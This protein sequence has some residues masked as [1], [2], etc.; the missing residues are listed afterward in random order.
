MPV[1]LN[2]VLYE[3]VKEYADSVYT[4]PSAYK[5]GFIVKTYKQLGGKYKDDRKERNL[6]RW[7]Q[8]KWTDIGG[9]EYPVYRPTVRINKKTPLTPG[10]IN[11]RNLIQ[12][13][14][15]KQEIKGSHNL[16]PFQRIHSYIM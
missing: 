4:K 14:L 8:E 5:S 13:I 16:P 1:P 3:R 7:F 6:K 2:P 15:R 11:T 10:E 12:Q 9:L